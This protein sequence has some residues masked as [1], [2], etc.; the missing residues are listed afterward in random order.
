MSEPLARLAAA[1]AALVTTAV[2]WSLPLESFP[3]ESMPRVTSHW[4]DPAQQQ[5]FA[6]VGARY[7]IEVGTQPARIIQV[8]VDDQPLLGEGGASFA[9]TDSAGRRW[10]PAPASI[11]PEWEVHT[12]QRM[13]PAASSRA[14]MNVWSAT[15]YYWDVHLLDIPFVPE[16]EIASG[17]VSLPIR[18]HVVF[19]AHPDRVHLEA[20]LQPVDGQSP[21][22][23]QVVLDPKAAD[24]SPLAGRPVVTLGSSLRVLSPEG[25]TFDAATKTLG[26]GFDPEAG[27][28]F[29]V[30]RPVE[31]SVSP[32]DAFAAELS[33]LPAA[34]FT[35]RDAAWMGYDPAAGLYVMHT[36][37]KQENFSFESAWKVP[38]RRIVAGLQVAAPDRDRHVTI[39][40]MTDLGNLEAG[41]ITDESGFPLP[42]GG[43]VAKNFA[44]EKEEPDDTAF[45]DVYFP[46]SLQAGQ[47]R[48]L[49]VMPLFQAWGNHMLKQVSSIRFFN[50][51]W[52]LSTGVSETT[53]FTHASMRIRGAQ[54][55]VPDFRPFSGPFMMGQPQHDC[56]TWPG[57]LHYTTSEGQIVP[58]Y[59]NTVF[60][61]V[62]PNLAQFTMQFRTSDDAAD[63][64]V[65]V[66]EIPQTDEARTFLRLRYDWDKAVEIAGDARMNFRWL[67]MFEKNLPRELVYLDAAS[68]PV[69]TAIAPTTQPT[70]RPV[71]VAE[72]LGKD[73]AFAGTH[74]QRLDFSSVA[75]V[76]R[77]K[78]RLGG[79]DL[80]GVHLSALFDARGGS[81]WFATDQETL[82][83]QP[84]DFIEADVLLMPH[85][86]VTQPTFK[87]MRE[88]EYWVTRPPV[89]AEVKVGTKVADFPMTVRA[90]DDLARF[91]V[92]GGLDTIAA[93]AEG[94][95]APA[96]PMLWEDTRWQ[97]QQVHGGD[98]YQVDRDRDGTYRF[99]FVYPI[100]GTEKHD[101][102]VTLVKA[103]SPVTSLADVNGYPVIRTQ[104]KGTIDLH[105]PIAFT[106]ATATF[107]AGEPFATIRAASADEIRGVPVR[108][109]LSGGS[110]SVAVREQAG[111]RFAL[112]VEG[113]AA[114]LEV[115]NLVNHRRYVV[116]V[117]GQERT[118]AANGSGVLSV[119]V[120][121]GRTDV[122]IR[123][124]AE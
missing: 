105:A 11:K 35:L 59:R 84:G 8:F 62:A 56:L 67:S 87:P 72:P 57:F 3:P 52:H 22:R 86:D 98:G 41:V 61:S 48:S 1:V 6:V 64:K 53:C 101:F 68:K 2:A 51:Y 43:F 117:G 69:V 110:A 89:V 31:P 27:P 5:R 93:V 40:C 24:A 63:M 14:R 58:L 78:G 29:W 47:S 103:S 88:R 18:G 94:F 9:V 36:L 16:D 46:L 106:G 75:V 90:T 42:I 80:D 79:R 65:E 17:K 71:V 112:A 120:A 119:P 23:V 83:I 123:P 38:T 55:S 39:K 77:F 113:D 121:A 97:D 104:S 91:S 116:T 49:Q 96:V 33:P 19:H 34:A 13:R 109:A 82:R 81:Y 108:L 28:T 25:G 92:T 95:S 20:K 7:R 73:G 102:T 107:R 85:A 12:G 30:L 115:T 37:A 76:Q 118:V 100:R 124:A 99:T 32:A 111:E 60:R 4:I 44:G 66:I 50:I 74:E 122:A 45:G 21:A 54:V 15:P 114:T 26:A 10:V 70:T